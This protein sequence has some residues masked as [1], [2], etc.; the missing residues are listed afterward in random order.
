VIGEVE[1]H[2][3]KPGRCRI[4]IEIATTGIRL[5]AARIVSERHEE[6]S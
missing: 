3:V 4:Q 1:I 6:S 5:G 2:L